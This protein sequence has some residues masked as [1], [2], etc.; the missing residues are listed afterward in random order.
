MSILIRRLIRDSFA[1]AVS[2]FDEWTLNSSKLSLYI[3]RN[4]FFFQS[5]ST[6]T[7]LDYFKHDSFNI[8]HSTY[9]NLFFF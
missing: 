1:I 2:L 8:F 3:T 9:I 5:S 7:K 4:N 6:F